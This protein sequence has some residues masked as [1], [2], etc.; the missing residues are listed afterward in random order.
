MAKKALCIGINDYP[1]TQNDFSG[2]LNDAHDWARHSRTRLRGALAPGRPAKKAAMEAA[3]QDLIGNARS[4]DSIVITYSGHGTFVP[5]TNGDEPDGRDEALCPYDIDKGNVLIDDEIHQLF[6][7]RA[8]GV[9]IVLISDSCHSGSVIRWAPPDAD[10]DSPRPRF[11]PP[12]AG[13]RK[14]SCRRTRTAKWR[15]APPAAPSRSRGWG[16]CRRPAGTS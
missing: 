12:A 4:G 10:S 14:T 3:F 6:G 1:G 8:K 15:H 5:D 16:R 2:C 7:Q 11:L 13:C 9:K